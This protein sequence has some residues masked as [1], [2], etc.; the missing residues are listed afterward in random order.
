VMDT[1]NIAI[2]VGSTRPGRSGASVASW[3]QKQTADRT[4]AR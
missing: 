1:L 2:I 4:A 3:V